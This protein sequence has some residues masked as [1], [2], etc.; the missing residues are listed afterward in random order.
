[1]LTQAVANLLDNALSY[2]PKGS[3]VKVLLG[4]NDTDATIRVQDNGH[5]IKPGEMQSIWKRFVR[6]SVASA[7]TPGMGLGLSL[8][9]AVAKAH[10]GSA[11]CD[12]RE[13]GG[14]EFWIRLLR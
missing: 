4:V 1:M 6:G 3:A 12:N 8:V 5:G 13:G 2:S 10:G 11:G 14:A 9:Q 7:G